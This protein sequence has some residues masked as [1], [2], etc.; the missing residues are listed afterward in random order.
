MQFTVRI[1]EETGE[2]IALI[3]RNMG[4]KKSDVARLALNQFVEK[5]MGERAESP[6]DRVKHLIGITESGT[7]DLGQKHREHLI[8]KI[9]EKS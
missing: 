5:E 9:R 8:R 7:Q 2:K 1:P 3:A 4:L 6:Y